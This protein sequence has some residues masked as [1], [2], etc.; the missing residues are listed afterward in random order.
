MK[1]SGGVHLRQ[2][3]GQ[4]FASLAAADG[5]IRDMQVEMDEKAVAAEREIVELQAALE[6]A[7][8]FLGGA[9][10][11]R[12]GFLSH[13]KALIKLAEDLPSQDVVLKAKLKATVRPLEPQIGQAAA[14]TTPQPKAESSG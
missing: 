13:V 14:G 8:T 1:V 4:A 7:T 3:V 12:T 6:T 9:A 2:L 10:T 5:K 11:V